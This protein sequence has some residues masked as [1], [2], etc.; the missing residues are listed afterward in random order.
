MVGEHVV[1]EDLSE[2]VV[3]Y[4]GHRPEIGIGGGVADQHVDPAEFLLRLVDEMA[5]LVFRRD[6][7]GDGDRRLAAHGCVDR[8]RRL[9]AG[10]EPA[11]GDDHCRAVAGQ[12]L[13]DGP[14]DAA[15][16][17]GDDRDAASQIEQFCQGFLRHIS[18]RCFFLN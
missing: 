14:A 5:K 17:P 9:F 7:R 16:G 4:A 1:V 13:G 15:R 2:L 3:G 18:S 12:G 10:I 11:R 8:R 6:V